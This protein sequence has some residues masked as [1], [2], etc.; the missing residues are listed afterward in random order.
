[1]HGI[2]LSSMRSG[3]GELLRGKAHMI[4]NGEGD[5]LEA[6]KKVRELY[7]REVVEVHLK[8]KKMTITHDYSRPNQPVNKVVDVGSTPIGQ[9]IIVRGGGD[10]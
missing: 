1:M 3:Q 10:S 2:D 9:S 4:L 6:L 7:V 5:E 8:E